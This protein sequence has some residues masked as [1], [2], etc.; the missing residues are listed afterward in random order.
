MDRVLLIDENANHA[1]RLAQRLRQRGLA[2]HIV[3]SIPEGSQILKQRISLFDIVLMAIETKPE[4]WIDSLRLLVESSLQLNHSTRPLF[5]FASQ[6]MCIPRT[7][8]RIEDIGAC[9]AHG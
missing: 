6:Q 5:L 1:E 9:Y 3:S 7:R 2:V 8:L 4:N